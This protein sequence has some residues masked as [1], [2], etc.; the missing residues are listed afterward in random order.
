MKID[1]VKLYKPADRNT[2]TISLK[3]SNVKECGL[4]PNSDVSVIYEENIKRIIITDNIEEYV[5]EK[6]EK[7]KIEKAKRNECGVTIPIR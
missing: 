2:I 4:T 1:L 6:I 3:L 7:E 5:K